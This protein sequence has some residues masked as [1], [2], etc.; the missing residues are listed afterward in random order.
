MKKAGLLTAAA[1]LALAACGTE[2]ENS[3][4]TGGAVSIEDV[5]MEPLEVEVQA[6]DAVDPGEEVTLGAQLTQGD[7][8]VDDAEEVLFEIWKD[9]EK[10]ESGDM[11]EAGRPGVEGVYDI[12]YTF[13]EEAV[14]YIQPHT[15]ARGTHVM[16]VEQV[17]VGDPDI[18]EL[19]DEDENH[20]DMNDHDHHGGEDDDHHHGNHEDDHTD[21]LTL[22]LAETEANAGEE[23]LL[24]V[25]AA[26]EEEGWENGDVRL[27]IWTHGDE[28]RDWID[29]EEAGDGRYEAAYTFTEAAEYH[30]VIHAEDEDIHEHEEVLFDVN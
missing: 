12:D 19:E 5:N 21:E 2:E 14:Y 15:T 23:V 17:I 28:V 7:E 29:M 27:E 9:G 10:G 6:P 22:N 26:L 11:I 24:Q 16:P 18:E 4:D 20:Q 25:D 8:H 30:V 3:N 13:E 1:V